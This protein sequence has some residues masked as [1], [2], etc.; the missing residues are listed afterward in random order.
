MRLRSLTLLLLVAALVVPA[1]A[2]NPAF[3]G[4]WRLD[5]AA[6]SALDGWQKADLVLALDGSRVDVR[7]DMTWRTTRLEAV[8]RLD[9]AAPVELKDFFRIE[10]RHMAVYPAKGGVTRATAEWIDAGRTLRTEAVTP[11]EV[12][13]GVVPLRITTEYRL[14]E[15]GDTLTVIELRSARN[16]PLVYVFRKVATP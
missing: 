11:V 2:A 15:L 8:N 5:P 9:T 14:G 1:A 4:R 6:S 3:A 13:Q 10:A 12:S 16:R 7:Y